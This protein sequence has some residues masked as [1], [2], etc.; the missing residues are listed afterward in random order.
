MTEEFNAF[1]QRKISLRASAPNV[2]RDPSG[3]RSK[4]QIDLKHLYNKGYQR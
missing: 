2:P 1:E 3:I 4:S